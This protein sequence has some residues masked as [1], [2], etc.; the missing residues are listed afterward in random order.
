MLLNDEWQHQLYLEWKR[1]NKTDKNIDNEV[2]KE[3]ARK[4]KRC[5]G[6][7]VLLLRIPL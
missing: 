5:P 2:P 7:L 1:T 3:T 6:L 4:N